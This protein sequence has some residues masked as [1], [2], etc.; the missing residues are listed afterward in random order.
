M[1]FGG[2]SCKHCGAGPFRN[3]EDCGTPSDNHNARCPRYL[4]VQGLIDD[5]LDPLK[6][7]LRELGGDLGAVARS[8]GLTV[9]GD[10][11][12]ATGNN[13]RDLISATRA[14][15]RELEAAEKAKRAEEERRERRAKATAAAKA[16]V[17][18]QR[19]AESQGGRWVKFEKILASTGNLND[20]NSIGEGGFGEVFRGKMS[21][22]A[23]AVKV[24]KAKDEADWLQEM[25]VRDGGKHLFSKSTRRT[26]F[27]R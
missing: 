3:G 18:L 27:S 10:G 7:Q 8:A 1:M 12:E 19:K 24:M 20:S 14:K 22:Q 16:D 9:N 2:V 13:I 4:D 5:E 15:I 25:K 26:I 17:S 6:S 21:G 11:I 23:V